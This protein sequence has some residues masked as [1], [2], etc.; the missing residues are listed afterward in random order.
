VLSLPKVR[1]AYRRLLATP[2]IKQVA[3]RYYDRRFRHWPGAFRGV[4]GTF[5]EATSAARTLDEVRIGYDYPELATMYTE[6]RGRIFAADYPVMFWLDRILREESTVFDFGGHIGIAFYGFESHVRYPGNLTW[7]VYDV[8]SVVAEGRKL[9][10]E[11]PRAALR[12]TEDV[13]E[14]T[15]H[16]VFH[17]AGALQYI[18]APLSQQLATLDA[19]PKHL[20]LNKLPLWSGESFVTLQN[21][22]H[23]FNPYHV[24]NREAFIAGLQRLGYRVVDAWDN[25]EHSCRPLNEPTHQ[26][27][28]YAGL[29]LT[30]ER[31]L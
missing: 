19:R 29:Y 23:S 1:S 14:L 22:M 31:D 28:T 18:E 21:T 25:W 10:A 8:P 13:S 7:T 16:A 27:P 17:A 5:A 30:L 4:Y 6:R 3:G 11:Q 20:L 12:F 26:V 2:G 9:L 15:R 24:F